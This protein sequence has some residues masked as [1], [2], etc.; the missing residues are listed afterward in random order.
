MDEALA[1][2]ELAGV[3]VPLLEALPRFAAM[4]AAESDRAPASLTAWSLAAK[5]A[6]DLVGRE[7]IIPRVVRANGGTEARFG[8]ALAVPEDAE[9]V[10][11]LAKSFPLAAHAV[12]ARTG[13]VATP[14]RR[15]CGRPRRCSGRSSMRRPTRSCGPRWASAR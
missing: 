7:R 11:E 5:L 6:L 4:T 2:R 9:R 14:G 12:P 13:S 10:V 8:V 3:T 1:P 15:R